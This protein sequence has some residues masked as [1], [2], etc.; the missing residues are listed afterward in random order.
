M[1]HRIPDAAGVG[2]IML[3]LV[4]ILGAIGASDC[5]TFDTG[6][7]LAQVGIGAA[8]VLGGL[9]LTS[10]ANNNHDKEE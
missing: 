4:A 10:A 7:A 8:V 5:G 9:M 1:K 3:G 2:L 6:R